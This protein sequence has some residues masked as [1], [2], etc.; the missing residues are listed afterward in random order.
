MDKRI[1]PTYEKTLYPILTED[2]RSKIV[3]WTFEDHNS[4]ADFIKFIGGFREPVR[5]AVEKYCN[6]VVGS[7][8]V[9]YERILSMGVA[10]L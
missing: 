4:L 1:I 6:L 9:K 7:E 10:E 3:R 8:I 2:E 5:R